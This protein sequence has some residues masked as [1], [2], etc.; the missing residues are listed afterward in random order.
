MKF[1]DLSI[2]EKRVFNKIILPTKREINYLSI[3]PH[4]IVKIVNL[5]TKFFKKRNKSK[6]KNNETLTF[7]LGNR[8]GLFSSFNALKRNNRKYVLLIKPYYL[9]YV[10]IANFFKKKII[11]VCKNNISKAIRSI[12]S[13]AKL[14]DII[15]ICNPNNFDGSFI[16]SKNVNLILRFTKKYNISVL[17]D[18]CYSDLYNKEYLVSPYLM[19]RFIKNPR[20]VYLNSLS[21]RS[22]LPGIRSGII[23]SKE[24]IIHDII[25]YKIISGTQLSCFNQLLSFKAWKEKKHVK[26]I[27]KNY[28]LILREVTN[29]LLNRSKL[30][31]Y[32]G[33]FYIA[34]CLKGYFVNSKTATKTLASSYGVAVSDGSNFGINNYIRLALVLSK[35]ECISA[36]KKIIIFLNGKK[37]SN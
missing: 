11:V 22:C 5:I 24:R 12:K 9:I 10:K 33:G 17:S 13:I 18:E 30:Q 19:N 8:D 4:I 6:F 26:Y 20:F 28:N 1:F 29:L 37:I 15:F 36:V 7:S 2:G 27:R 23:L 35:K 3:Y 34:I 14:I 32:C 25:N 21:K 16:N 31:F